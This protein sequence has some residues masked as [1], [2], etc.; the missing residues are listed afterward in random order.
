MAGDIFARVGFQQARSCHGTLKTGRSTDS[1]QT[2]RA[3]RPLLN[4]SWNGSFQTGSSRSSSRLGIAGAQS[5]PKLKEYYT[6]GKFCL[7]QARFFQN[8]EPKDLVAVEKLFTQAKEKFK[9]AY[10]EIDPYSDFGTLQKGALKDLLAQTYLERGDFFKE[11]GAP[12]KARRSYKKAL[13]YLPENAK[14]EIERRLNE[15][16][17]EPSLLSKILPEWVVSRAQ[18]SEQNKIAHQHILKSLLAYT[19]VMSQSLTSSIVQSDISLFE[20]NPLVMQLGPWPACEIGFAD[21]ANTQHLAYY[22]QRPNLPDDQRRLLRTLAFEV[23]EIFETKIKSSEHI[24]EIIPL[25]RIP[26]KELYKQIINILAQELNPSSVL[27]LPLVKGLTAILQDCPTALLMR[28]EGI[29]PGVNEKGIEPG[30]LMPL[31]NILEKCLE[32][33]CK[34]RSNENLK[35]LLKAITQLFDVIGRTSSQDFNIDDHKGLLATL[36]TL[37][38]HEDAALA[39]QASCAYQACAQTLSVRTV[40]QN[41]LGPLYEVGGGMVC[42]SG[43][44]VGFEVE[45]LLDAFKHFYS[46]WTDT[47]VIRHGSWYRTLW[48]A[49]LFLRLNKLVEFEHFVRNSSD[50]EN[51]NF[52]LGLCQR[53]EQIVDKHQDLKTRQS[54]FW[55]LQSLHHDNE[56]WGGHSE[57]KASALEAIQRVQ[58]F[59]VGSQYRFEASDFIEQAPLSTKLLSNAVGRLLKLPESENKFVLEPEEKLVDFFVAVSTNKLLRTQ[60][61]E[62]KGARLEYLESAKKEERIAPRGINLTNVSEPSESS[63]SFNLDQEVEQF[64]ASEQKTL[65]LLGAAGSGKTDFCQHLELQLWRQYPAST[66]FSSEPIPILIPFSSRRVHAE[67]LISDFFQEQGFSLQQIKMLRKTRRFVFILDGYD[68]VGRGN[69]GFYEK[70][71]LDGWHAKFVI[72]SRPEYL[73]AGDE[74]K[75]HSPGKAESLQICQLAPFSDAEI[76]LYIKKYVADLK[77]SKRDAAAYAELLEKFDL[78]S[79]KR[80]PFTL[81]ALLEAVTKLDKQG[82]ASLTQARIYEEFMK[83]WFVYHHARLE[84]KQEPAEFIQQGIQFSQDIALEMYQDAQDNQSGWRLNNDEAIERHLS[85]YPMPLIRQYACQAQDALPIPRYQ[86]IDPSLQAYLVARAL[87]AGMQ[88]PMWRDNLL[89]QVSLAKEPA[90]LNF[91]TEFVK[92]NSDLEQKCFAW[93]ENAQLDQACQLGAKNASA[94]LVN[95]GVSLDRKNSNEIQEAPQKNTNTSRSLSFIQF[96]AMDLSNFLLPSYKRT[97]FDLGLDVAGM[98]LNRVEWIGGC[99]S[100]DSIDNQHPWAPRKSLSSWR[101]SS[102]PDIM[103]AV[104]GKAS[105]VV[106]EKRI[107]NVSELWLR[108][109]FFA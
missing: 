2:G 91:L 81:K 83:S 20:R 75:F 49:D 63:E 16:P 86:F 57:V 28:G 23:L 73:E 106:G 65:L 87:S 12:E 29:D 45:K 52:G 61:Q 22:L 5:S 37:I 88:Q 103:S 38:G 46:A 6:E 36:S 69:E 10:K 32:A 3:D 51:K 41:A 95:A 7:D 47:Q 78:E 93:I 14:E 92:Q 94:L 35:E 109:Q 13:T 99:D 105:E 30:S 104:L 48:F 68:K 96:D 50:C 89:N 85:Y 54:A 18:G 107:S 25:A 33:A 82:E 42:L 72:T 17:P 39:H 84:N 77:G 102:G 70:N 21:I 56:L 43:A 60:V 97:S 4:E 79:L 101:F 62:L 90:V 71:G 40:W 1:F 53:L 74:G 34:G 27:N 31:L 67:N 9:L 58:K 19:P 76:N 108:P 80:S 100:S 15:L 98:G 44:V 11:L 24:Q 55:F 59:P 66:E 26:D 64:F 8:Q